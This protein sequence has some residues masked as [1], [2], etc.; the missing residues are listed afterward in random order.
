[1]MPLFPEKLPENI[2][3]V[4]ADVVGVRPP[5]TPVLSLHLF[6]CVRSERSDDAAL[7]SANVCAVSVTLPSRKHCFL[8]EV[9]DNLAT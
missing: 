6:L 8:T 5:P 2:G 4:K 7:T 1:M 3:N 9:M